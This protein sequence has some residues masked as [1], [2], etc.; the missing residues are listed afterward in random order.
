MPQR[1]KHL[2]AARAKHKENACLPGLALMLN[3]SAYW[4]AA[5][6]M[7][8][9]VCVCARKAEKLY[10]ETGNETAYTLKALYLQAEA[11]FRQQRDESAEEILRR[12]ISYMPAHTTA[13]HVANAYRSVRL[14][15][16]A[17]R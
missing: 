10:S 8:R 3:C 11:L 1:K 9:P 16:Y 6:T 13:F 12:I 7:I 2:E 5:V 15:F 17:P 4:A 14:E